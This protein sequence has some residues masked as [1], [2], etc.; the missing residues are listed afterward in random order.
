MPEQLV[1]ELDPSPAPISP[2]EEAQLQVRMLVAGRL[3]ARTFRAWLAVSQA[4]LAQ[5]PP[6]HEVLRMIRAMEP[7]LR[8]TRGRASQ[9]LVGCLRQQGLFE[10]AIAPRPLARIKPARP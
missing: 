4:R 5:I 7:E 1:L 3:R 6:E 8:R 9:E 2:E 10:Q